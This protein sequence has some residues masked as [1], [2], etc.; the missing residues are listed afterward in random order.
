MADC[1]CACPGPTCITGDDTIDATDA[2]GC[3]TLDLVISDSNTV[4]LTTVNNRLEATMIVDPANNVIQEP[5]NGLHVPQFAVGASSKEQSWTETSIGDNVRH[6]TDLLVPTGDWFIAVFWN[7]WMRKVNRNVSEQGAETFWLL[8]VDEFRG[9]RKRH[10]W[11]ATAG[12]LGHAQTQVA[13]GD[14][15]AKRI[16]LE[17]TTLIECSVLT[18]ITSSRNE[19]NEVDYHSSILSVQAIR[20]F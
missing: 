5:G 2:G 16:T 12:L 7:A 20:D 13:V 3:T 17:E 8:S 19:D 6:T 14:S 1:T 18:G 10:R 9:R 11:G 4:D 15:Y